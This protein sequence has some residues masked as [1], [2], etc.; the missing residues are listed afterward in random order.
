MSILCIRKCIRSFPHTSAS[1]VNIG[2]A[3]LSQDTPVT[4]YLLCINLFIRI[5]NLQ[6]ANVDSRQLGKL[7][8]YVSDA[9]LSCGKICCADARAASFES[10]ADVCGNKESNHARPGAKV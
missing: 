8:T 2:M 6:T 4:D 1:D 10:I 3:S 7:V 9:V 5:E